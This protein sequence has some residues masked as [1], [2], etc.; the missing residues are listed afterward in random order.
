MRSI[1]KPSN[2]LPSEIEYRLCSLIAENVSEDRLLSNT[3]ELLQALSLLQHNAAI[4]SQSGAAISEEA[5]RLFPFYVCNLIRPNFE[6]YH[7][8]VEKSAGTF[9][10]NRLYDSG[11]YTPYSASVLDRL[12]ESPVDA[13]T[14][15]LNF[16]ADIIEGKIPLFTGH[17][18][19]AEFMLYGTTL[20][21]RSK[22][23]VAT[24]RPVD[25]I[26][27]SM[28]SWICSSKAFRK[29]PFFLNHILSAYG[30]DPASMSFRE[31]LQA[32]ESL[33]RLRVYERAYGLNHD[34]R[35]THYISG[36][37]IDLG[38]VRFLIENVRSINNSTLDALLKHHSIFQS[39]KFRP[40][41]LNASVY[42]ED[43]IKNKD[44]YLELSSKFVDDY[45]P[46]ERILY[47][48]LQDRSSECADIRL[49]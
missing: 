42:S 1:V 38:L 12:S 16:I 49:R 14:Y 19:L 31:W 29:T 10:A 2:S 17:Y 11:I 41:D 3:S 37:S 21:R 36:G 45:I 5:M 28:Y 35:Y 32:P 30:C 13:M 6:L 4:L 24:I 18:S 22:S 44:L 39:G 34:E 20:P 27:L 9:F 46:A 8:H 47:S 23:I 25:E 43:A 26:P 48:M 15:M 33:V 7:L 40:E